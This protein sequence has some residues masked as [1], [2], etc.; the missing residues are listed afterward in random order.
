MYILK[1]GNFVDL[2]KDLKIPDEILQ[3][4]VDPKL[5]KQAMKK[6]GLIEETPAPV[7][8]PNNSV[9]TTITP[10]NQGWSKMDS[11]SNSDQS[12]A[13]GL[14]GDIPQPV[15]VTET[16][17]AVPAPTGWKTNDFEYQPKPAP[18][19]VTLKFSNQVQ[20]NQ[21]N[22]NS[23]ISQQLATMEDDNYGWNS[24]PDS[25]DSSTNNNSNPPLP[26]Q[27]NIQSSNNFSENSTNQNSHSENTNNNTTNPDNSVANNNENENVQN[28]ANY[29]YVPKSLP[30]GAKNNFVIVGEGASQVGLGG[31][32][33]PMELVG[34]VLK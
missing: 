32:P 18:I 22:N 27:P 21:N 23:Q 30:V 16:K 1:H 20:N 8:A 25:M 9:E 11:N 2:G 15:S 33:K 34:W 29:E 7:P 26:N 4:F 28:D 6:K 3:R 24:L 14:L 19:P 10:A 31:L 12:K 5:L 13:P 17:P